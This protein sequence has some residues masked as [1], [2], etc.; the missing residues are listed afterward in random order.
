LFVQVLVDTV[1]LDTVPRRALQ[2]PMI[3]LQRVCNHCDP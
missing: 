3:F 1:H 2:A